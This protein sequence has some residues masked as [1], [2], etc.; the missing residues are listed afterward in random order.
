MDAMPEE[1]KRVSCHEGFSL[2]SRAGV[3]GN[4]PF[5]GKLGTE[6]TLVL[7]WL[8]QSEHHFTIVIQ[9]PQMVGTN[10]V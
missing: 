5:R 6:Q 10:Q 7:P 1:G 3:D 8:V 2:M 4:A 9:T